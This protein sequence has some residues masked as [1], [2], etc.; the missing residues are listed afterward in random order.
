MD[1]LY[2]QKS[3]QY[4]NGK[5]YGTG[6]NEVVTTL[7][8]V[9]II[10]VAGSYRDIVAISCVSNIN[11]DILYQVWTDVVGNTELGFDITVAMNDGH[12]SNM[13]FFKKKVSDGFLKT[14]VP[15]PLS[16]GKRISL[17]FDTTHLFKNVYNNF[18]ISY[19]RRY[20]LKMEATPC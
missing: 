20:L 17:L 4:S 2:V 8:C 9:M 19:V 6:N 13:K 10:S 18:T 5:F 12:S 11:A 16:P 3:I 15:N 7:L 1:E 14:W